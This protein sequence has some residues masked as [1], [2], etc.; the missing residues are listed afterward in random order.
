MHFASCLFHVVKYVVLIEPFPYGRLQCTLLEQRTV[1]SR[2][3]RSDE[4]LKI[5]TRGPKKLFNN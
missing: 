2:W 5:V 1:S 3:Q 4:Y